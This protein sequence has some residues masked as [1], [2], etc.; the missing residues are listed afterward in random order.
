[1]RGVPPSP[2]APLELLALREKSRQ[3]SRFEL[4]DFSSAA[5]KIRSLKTV[6][7]DLVT[8]LTKRCAQTWRF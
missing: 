8:K 7:S 3:L 1:M 6:L 2:W 5:V 4:N